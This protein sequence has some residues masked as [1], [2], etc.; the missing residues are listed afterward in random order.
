MNGTTDF[1]SLAGE[2]EERYR[3]YLK[4]T[5]FFRDRELRKSFDEALRDPSAFDTRM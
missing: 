4:T 3:R 1:V 2:V 5:F